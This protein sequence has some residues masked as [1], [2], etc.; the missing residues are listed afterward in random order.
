MQ[1]RA[2]VRQTKR[3]ES[4]Q[5]SM[6]DAYVE[7]NDDKRAGNSEIH[8]RNQEWQVPEERVKNEVEIYIGTYVGEYGHTY[9]L[10]R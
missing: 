5:S 6:L 3:N 1:S 2:V 10:P 7:M 9:K 8:G 4:M